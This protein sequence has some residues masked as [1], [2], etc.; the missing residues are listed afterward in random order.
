MSAGRL[1]RPRL[2]LFDLD[3]TLVDTA[4]DIAAAVN[5]LLSVH[6]LPA[7]SLDTVRSMIGHGIETLVVRAFAAHGLTL[8]GT[9]LA[10][11]HA[12]MME[13]Y[14]GHLTRFSSPRD[15]ARDAVAVARRTGL[16]TGVVT[17]KPE[18]FSRT[19]LAELDLLAGLD[20]VIGGDSGF[21]KKP[22]P[23]ML[24]AACRE[25]GCGPSDALLVG[26]SQADLAAAR[27]AGMACILVRGGYGDM[28]VDLLDADRVM[29]DLREFPAL[30]LRLLEAA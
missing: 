15:G 20:M 26:D 14:G 4:P 9:E 3:G 10:A 19:I 25:T 27:A 23:D 7:H 29:H 5:E 22:A 2:V 16:G 12:E 18:G 6:R 24:L 11:R 17:N 28:D 8:Q 1:T 13:I 30:L 21:A